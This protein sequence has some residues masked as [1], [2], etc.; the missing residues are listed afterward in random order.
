MILYTSMPTEQIFPVSQ[1][2][3]EQQSVIS[4]KGAD[5]IVEKVTDGEF[6][7]VR[8]LSTNPDHFLDQTYMPGQMI[9]K[10]F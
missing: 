7:I 5:V 8:L 6:R 10:T 3:Y 2:A 9:T 1:D 4:Y